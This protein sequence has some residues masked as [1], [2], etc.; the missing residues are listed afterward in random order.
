MLGRGEGLYNPA[1]NFTVKAN[2]QFVL[3]S[4]FN[5]V[6]KQDLAVSTGNNR[7]AI[8]TGNGAGGFG[9]AQFF[10]VK[11]DIQAITASDLN[12]DGIQDL[13]VTGGG[14]FSTGF[15][16]ILIGDGT[17][18]FGAAINYVPGETTKSISVIVKTDTINELDEH[19]TSYWRI[20]ST[21]PS[22]TVRAQGRFSTTTR[23]RLF[24]LATSLSLK[25]IAARATPFSQ[26][27]YRSRAA[28]LS[29]WTT[30]LRTSR[31]RL[32]AITW[33]LRER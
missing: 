10:T 7:I 17:G 24:P 28:S 20:L 29:S 3:V 11:G 14:Y 2:P 8:L 6:G 23:L 15:V 9:A 30:R 21:R 32:A 27:P 5:G 26:S 4:D 22:L 19:S 13:A 33:P 25:T 18:S 12:G 16:S 31:R 1:T